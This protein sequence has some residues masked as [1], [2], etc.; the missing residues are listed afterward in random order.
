MIRALLPLLLLCAACCAPEEPDRPPSDEPIRTP[1]VP[2]DP[3]PADDRGPSDSAPPSPGAPGSGTPVPAPSLSRIR[4]LLED[5]RREDALS[6]LS[7]P[8]MV[9]GGDSA[10]T[11]SAFAAA[12]LGANT[13]A[14]RTAKATE[15]TAENTKRLVKEAQHG[16]PVFG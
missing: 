6:G 16:K 9:A 8:S 5:G 4:S 12:R 13:A 15:E 1:E 10:G 14:D 11:F 7:L 3:V 2:Q